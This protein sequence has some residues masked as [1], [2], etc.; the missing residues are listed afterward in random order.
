[1][2][3]PVLVASLA[4]VCSSLFAGE[5]DEW[6][7]VARFDRVIPDVRGMVDIPFR[8]DLRLARGVSFDFRVDDVT[9]FQGYRCYFKCGGGW[10]VVGFQP[11]ESGETKRI[12]VLK[13]A[14]RTEDKPD[15]WKDVEIL[16]VSGW[17]A[18][19][20]KASFTVSNLRVEKAGGDVLVLECWTSGPVMTALDSIGV[21]GC[22]VGLDDLTPD[23]VRAAKALIV[24]Y[25]AELDGAQRRRLD[26]L[27]TS[28]LKVRFCSQADRKAFGG[29][30]S[31]MKA[32]MTDIVLG[33]WPEA[34]DRIVA[35]AR[36]SAARADEELAWLKARPHEAPA[37]EFRAFW[38][39]EP[40]GVEGKTWE[41]VATAL[42]SAGF[43][44]VVANLSWGGSAAYDSKFVARSALVP[45]KVDAYAECLAACRRHGLQLH[46][47]H[48]C[49]QLG[50][51]GTP[52][53]V[54]RRMREEGRTQM[55]FGG[56]PMKWL[57]PTD[58]RNLRHEA[59]VVLEMAKK[60]ADG[61]HLDYIRFPNAD[62]C[63]CDGCR[64]RFERFLAHAVTNWPSCVRTDSSLVSKWKAFRNDAIT[65]LVREIGRR[66]RVETPGVKVSAAVLPWPKS[67]PDGA[68][69]DW[70]A[71]RK[72]GLLDF[73]CPMDYTRSHANFA[74]TIREQFAL[75]GA[76]PIYPGIGLYESETTG[77]GRARRTVRQIED[78]RNAGA[79]G[80]VI[81]DLSPATFEYVERIG[82]VL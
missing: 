59:D 80:F 15:G 49:W 17:R 8:Q 61:V 23:V 66:V 65:G 40:G 1:M 50:W 14:A 26:D 53:E 3:L 46:A 28:G 34:A 5:A 63:F 31:A 77:E 35:A 16:R 57:C 38:C 62:Q 9:A 71:W 78:G 36:A 30:E 60:G 29:A 74:A 54:A 41:E 79:K 7:A 47:W 56:K 73:Y 64:T 33:L 4:T 20:K 6:T 55:S 72:E 48:V 58:P 37:D 24:P 27:R 45:P 75:P 22:S 39:H 68:A 51:T 32:R 76:A 10:Y 11:G 69:Q 67:T 70:A 42:E 44:A 25:G 52:P 81:F 43:N 19:R 13:S 21:D 18:S 2:K 82:I 12:T